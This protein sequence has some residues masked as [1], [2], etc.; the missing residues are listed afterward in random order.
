M[1]VIVF[2][3]VVGSYFKSGMDHTCSRSISTYHS[4]PYDYDCFGFAH[5]L[6]DIYETAAFMFIIG[7]LFTF[8]VSLAF[9]GMNLYLAKFY[10][11]D[12]Q[13]QSIF[14]NLYSLFVFVI[15]GLSVMALLSFIAYGVSIFFR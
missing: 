12:S 14:F 2:L 5:E 7:F 4:A 11:T 15:S 3:L 8:P 6:A 9:C 1:I 10:L 13:T